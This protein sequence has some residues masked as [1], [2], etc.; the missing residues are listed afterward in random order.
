MKIRVCIKSILIIFCFFFIERSNSYPAVKFKFRNLF[1]KIVILIQKAVMTFTGYGICTPE[2]I[3][4]PDDGLLIAKMINRQ[5][6]TD[7]ML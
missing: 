2:K 7:E 3:N 1:K 6:I 5:E 4:P